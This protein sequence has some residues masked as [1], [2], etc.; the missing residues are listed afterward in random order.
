M[1]KK[2][3]NYSQPEA[4]HFSEES[5]LLVD[6][7]LKNLST[8]KKR[9]LDIGAGS[10]IIGIEYCLLATS[11]PQE[12]YLVEPQDVFLPHLKNNIN[13]IDNVS[14]HISSQFIQ[15]FKE[16]KFDLILSNP[17][18][19]NPSKGRMSENK[20]QNFCRFSTHLSPY[21]L[22]S[23]IEC[24]LSQDGESWVI[25]GNDKEQNYN[26]DDFTHPNLESTIFKT[27][28]WLILRFIKLNKD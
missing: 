5:L 25:V 8:S 12:L 18:Y 11:K 24:L 22:V 3:S 13:I 10:G 1:L 17:P 19:Y 4:Y 20:V 27:S 9:I 26:I 16:E 15:D 21:D 14:I 28:R 23:S 6:L 7:V 2:F